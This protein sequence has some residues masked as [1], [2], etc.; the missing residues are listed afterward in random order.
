[1]SVQQ[2]SNWTVPQICFV[3]G[4]KGN[5]EQQRISRILLMNFVCVL[6]RKNK[7]QDDFSH[8][9]AVTCTYCLYMDTY[10]NVFINTVA[11]STAVHVFMPCNDSEICL[12][13]RLSSGVM[14]STLVSSKVKFT[15]CT[16]S[17]IKLKKKKKTGYA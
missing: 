5:R 15:N 12:W 7:P 8:Y 4:M 3:E 9:F 2:A 1:M 10:V 16:G 13:H 17:K 6:L 14:P 11:L